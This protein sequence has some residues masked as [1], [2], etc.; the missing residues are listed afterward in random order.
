VDP[1]FEALGGD[2]RRAQLLDGEHYGLDVYEVG[3]ILDLDTG[4]RA[5]AL[6]LLEGSAR[7]LLPDSDAG[8]EM[9]QGD[10][11]LLPAAVGA[12]RFESAAAKVIAV[13]TK[14]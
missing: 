2:N 11:W 14:A 12:F 1:V 10:T 5:Q 6:V 8:W 4:G 13:D 9:Q 7:I 3:S